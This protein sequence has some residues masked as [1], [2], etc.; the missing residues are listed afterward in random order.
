MNL[1]LAP[2]AHRERID[3]MSARIVHRGPDSDGKFELPHLALAIRRLSIIDLVT[4]NQPLFNETDVPQVMETVRAQIA[5][6]RAN[7]KSG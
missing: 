3:A 7:N 1:A 2:L 6:M 5:R 4:G